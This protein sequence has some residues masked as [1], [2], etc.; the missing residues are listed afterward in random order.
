[1]IS[2]INFTLPLLFF[3]ELLLKV[4]SI[5]LRAE[6]LLTNTLKDEGIF[7]ND[8]SI[9]FSGFESLILLQITCMNYSKHSSEQSTWFNLITVIE[10]PIIYNISFNLRSKSSLSL[11]NLKVSSLVRICV[12]FRVIQ[13]L[14]RWILLSY[15]SYP[16]KGLKMISLI[17]SLIDFSLM[18][19][20]FSSSIGFSFDFLS[21]ICSF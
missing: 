15:F 9:H 11:L 5:F 8:I 13:P 21:A 2:Y 4:I 20:F 19:C 14:I 7:S 10:L 3:I 17:L 18:I 6:H 1:M 12:L 16:I